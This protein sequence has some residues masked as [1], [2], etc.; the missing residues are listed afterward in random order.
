M[1]YLNIFLLIF[2]CLCTSF[3]GYDVSRLW[4]KHSEID[5]IF[6][7]HNETKQLN[8]S[9]KDI[10]NVS[11]RLAIFDDTQDN[12]KTSLALLGQLVLYPNVKK[13]VFI[14]LPLDAY[15]N[16]NHDSVPIAELDMKQA[17]Q[18][19]RISE[20]RNI[21]Y[22]H[23][24]ASK[25]I[26]FFNILGGLHLFNREDIILKNSL[27]QHPHGAH[28]YSGE[29]ILEYILL[30]RKNHLKTQ[31][32]DFEK[33]FRQKSTL[34]NLFWQFPSIR[35]KTDESLAESLYSFITTN[36][37][38]QEIRKILYYIY[39]EEI[40]LMSQSF[41]FKETRIQKKKIVMIDWPKT[42][43]FFEKFEKDLMTYKKKKDKANLIVLNATKRKRLAAKAKVILQ[44]GNINIT[45]VDNYKIKPMPTSIFLEHSGNTEIA[46]RMQAVLTFSPRQVYFS[47]ELSDVNGTLILG[48]G[49]NLKKI[50]L[51][52]GN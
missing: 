41:I 13:M 25:L 48:K 28:Y 21:Y 26:R 40:Q 7:K 42:K 1:K 30:F 49:M 20:S 11:F 43:T 34:F 46:K 39:N 15:Y 10:K 2:L 37:S 18:F 9:T 50:R 47:A 5:K 31:A 51:S 12:K 6:L 38:L 36:L 44:K 32:L 14:N 29:Q 16:N 4:N 3:C 24:H 8:L 45:F 17:D 23:I 19:Y 27:Y 33:L 52:K 35:K 22:I